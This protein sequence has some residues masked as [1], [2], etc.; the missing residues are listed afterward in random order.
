[1]HERD[2]LLKAKEIY[3]ETY[4]AGPITYRNRL[5]QIKQNLKDELMLDASEEGEEEVHQSV[6]LMADE[7]IFQQES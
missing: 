1:M 5:N 2:L 7:E 6:D 4:G 3:Y